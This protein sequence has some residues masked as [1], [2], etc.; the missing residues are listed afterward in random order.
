MLLEKGVDP[1]ISSHA[2]S[3][4]I[5]AAGH[6]KYEVVKYLLEHGADVSSLQLLDFE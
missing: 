4:L 6:E 5:W 3:P 1:E 2:G